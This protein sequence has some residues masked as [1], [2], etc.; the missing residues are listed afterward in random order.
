MRAFV[1]PPVPR[2]LPS[3]GSSALWQA[4]SPSSDRGEER[5][6]KSLASLRA[7]C[8]PRL[9]SEQKAQQSPAAGLQQG[10]QA[11]QSS[12]FPHRQACRMGSLSAFFFVPSCH[13]FLSGVSSSLNQR[14]AAATL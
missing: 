5:A 7:T 2:V 14:A 12:C 9:D 4:S 6:G 3:P 11:H 10:E 8:K 1:V 13:A